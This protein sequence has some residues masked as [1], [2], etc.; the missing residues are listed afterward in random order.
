MVRVISEPTDHRVGSRSKAANAEKAQQ[1]LNYSNARSAANSAAL[2]EIGELPGV[3]DPARRMECGLSLLSF[4]TTYFPYSTGLSPFGQAQLDAIERIETAILHNAWIANILPRGFVKSTI[5]EN[6]TLWALLYGYRKYVMFFASSAGLSETAIGSIKT[7]LTTNPLLIEDFPEAT[8][9]LIRLGGKTMRTFSQTYRGELT[10]IE[11]SKDALR[12]ATI[13]GFAGSAGIVQ[14]F[15]LL[16]PPRGARFKDAQGRNVRPDLAIADDPS[17]DASAVSPVQNATRL[18]IIKSSVSMLGGHGKPVSLVVNATVIAEGDLASTISDPEKS[19]EWQAVKSPMITSMPHSLDAMWLGKYA[20]LRRKYDRDDPMGRVKARAKSTAYYEAHRD[21]MDAGGSVAWPAIGL[22]PG[23]IS[24]LQHGINILIDKGEMT[25]AAECQNEPLKPKSISALDLTE[26]LAD[27]TNGLARYVL[28]RGSAYLTFG[29]DVHDSVLFYTVMAMSA[30]MST[31][32]VVDYGC[33][34]PQNKKVFSLAS[35]KETLQDHYGTP[36]SEEAIALGVEDL[37]SQIQGQVYV[38]EQGKQVGI[39]LGCV[40][41]GY[42]ATEVYNAL[43]HLLP[44]SSNVITTKGTAVNLTKK[45]FAEYDLSPKRVVRFGPTPEDVR[46]LFAR[47]RVYA[48]GRLFDAIFDSNHFKSLLASR[49]AGNGGIELFAGDDHD[50]YISHFLS[51]KPM[52]ISGDG[53]SVCVWNS[54]RLRDNHYFDTAVLCVVAASMAGGR[55]PALAPAPLPVVP[56][57][58]RPVRPQVDDL[59][60]NRS[61]YEGFF[62]RDDY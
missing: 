18:N 17:S 26:D 38:D 52:V 44:L 28:P 45:P 55:V 57:P 16:A 54:N 20:E 19:P 8:V 9:P 32:A 15:G 29:I 5:S 39:S 46:W 61:N 7:E 24:A 27:K 62:S 37:V 1:K 33:F 58:P 36:T 35:A 3:V 2:A 51:E 21:M 53:R 25:F 43:T 60:P 34:P 40:D 31:G 48:S 47:D 4:L 10:N 50:F 14:G 6:A 23:E 12:L 11:Y 56:R 13:P 30:D 49:L 22:D 59:L 41:R 42:R